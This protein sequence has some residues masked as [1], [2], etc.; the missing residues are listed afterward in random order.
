MSI[1][2]IRHCFNDLLRSDAVENVR[3]LRNIEAV[4][5]IDELAVVIVHFVLGVFA[6]DEKV[7]FDGHCGKIIALLRRR[8]IGSRNGRYAVYNAFA[9]FGFLILA[10]MRKYLKFKRARVVEPRLNVFD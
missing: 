9:L 1:I 4:P 7:N 10:H 2:G 3:D 6:F 5:L 8:R